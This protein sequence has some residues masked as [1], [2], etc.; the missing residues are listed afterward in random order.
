MSRQLNGLEIAV[1]GMSPFPGAANVST[2]WNNLVN[3]KESIAFFTVD[4]LLENG[5]EPS[6]VSHPNYVRAKGYLEN[7][8]QFDS[9]FF[10]Y[11]P[12]EAEVMDPPN[13]YLS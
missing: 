5:I 1:I 3:G 8:D 12:L 2:Y 9:S 10:N 11:S 4:E 6:V 13:S 7:S